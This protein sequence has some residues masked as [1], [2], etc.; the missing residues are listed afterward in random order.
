MN[1]VRSYLNY[2]CLPFFTAGNGEPGEADNDYCKPD[3]QLR[4]SFY[5]VAPIE[6]TLYKSLT[7]R[8]NQTLVKSGRWHRH[9]RVG[10]SLQR[11][12]IAR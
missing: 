10:G 12:H 6:D 8:I 3:G 9:N 11:L 5:N 7:R 4:L 1:D 2:A